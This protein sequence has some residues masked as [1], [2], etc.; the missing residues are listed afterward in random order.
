MLSIEV[1]AEVEQH[2]RHLVQESFHGNK[3]A[4]FASLLELHEKYGWKER[5]RKDV[6]AVRAEVAQQGDVT[7]A[8]IEQAIGTYRKRR[9]SSHG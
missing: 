9:C 6:E 7:S 2:F 4:A 5:L 1:P 3:G 8:S